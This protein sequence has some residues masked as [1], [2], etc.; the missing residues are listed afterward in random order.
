MVGNHTFQVFSFYTLTTEIDTILGI[1][2]IKSSKL[3]KAFIQSLIV[4]IDSYYIR[5]GQ[6]IFFQKCYSHPTIWKIYTREWTDGNGLDYT[7]ISIQLNFVSWNYSASYYFINIKLWFYFMGVS[8]TN[9]VVRDPY[10][11]GPPKNN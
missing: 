7:F 9:F 2:C 3:S 10:F 5:Q 1:N 4:T 6:C 11:I 8:G